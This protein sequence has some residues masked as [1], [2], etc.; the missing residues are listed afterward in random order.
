MPLLKLSLIKEANKKGRFSG[1]AVAK[2]RSKT[3]FSLLKPQ[4]F[5]DFQYIQQVLYYSEI[6]S[7]IQTYFEKV[8]DIHLIPVNASF[9]SAAKYSLGRH[10]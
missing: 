8:H 7:G 5:C 3:M 10:F 4:A 9:S 2:S 1:D 6:L